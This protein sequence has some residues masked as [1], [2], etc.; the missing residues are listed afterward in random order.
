MRIFQY[1]S[2]TEYGRDRDG[3]YDYLRQNNI[4]AEKYFY[5]ITCTDQDCFYG[6]NIKTDAAGSKK[7]FKTNID[8]TAV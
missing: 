7:Y 4:Y 5:P 1:L 2:K 3:L 6:I 8:F